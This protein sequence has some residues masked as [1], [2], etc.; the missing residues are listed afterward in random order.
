MAVSDIVEGMEIVIIF[1]CNKTGRFGK[2]TE[3]TRKKH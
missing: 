3:R 2:Q 1:R